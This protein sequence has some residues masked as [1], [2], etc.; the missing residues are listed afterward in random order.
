MI[1]QGT[2]LRVIDN[3]GARYGLCIKVLKKSPRSRACLGDR[4]II[5]VKRAI[6]EK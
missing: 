5:V 2:L 6:P 4:V 1:Y 3:S